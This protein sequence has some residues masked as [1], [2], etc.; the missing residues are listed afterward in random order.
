MTRDPFDRLRDANPVPEDTLPPPAMS[1]ADRIVHQRALR[2]PGGWPAWAISASVAL[3]VLFIGG[4]WLLWVRGDNR[5]PVASSP[6][7][8]SAPADVTT[9][10]A[11]PPVVEPPQEIPVYLLLDA[12]STHYLPGPYL[13]PVSRS[14]AVLSRPVG[15]PVLTAV[16]FLLAGPTPGEAEA[17]PAASTAIPPGTRVLG[18]E[19][20][21]R[22][23]TVDLSAE[24][25]SGGGTLSMR[26][27]LAQVVFTLTRFDHID[28]VRF[29][30]EGVPTTVF[31][32]EGVMVGDP[33]TRD[34]F[35][36]L[37]PL[38]MIE[39]PTY[40]GAASDSPL[41]VEGTANV[42]EA[43]VSL[44]LVDGNGLIIWEGF[45]TATCGSGCR[46]DFS[47]EIPYRVDRDQWGA[48]IGWQESMEDGSQMN[49]R[50]HPV[51]LVADTG[52]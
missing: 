8:T 9:T 48:V 15:D 16:E 18:L 35:D 43:T 52:D 12:D 36:D 7:Q 23:A 41:L 39:T 47:I 2:S 42:F 49:V 31:G 21:G 34:E 44:V 13:V 28:G 5:S 25:T 6:P 29:L 30:V 45:T 10:A 38:V 24:F 51:W 27:R 46:G 40:W 17:I 3:L 19:V 37:L 22:V 11:P 4:G 20:S 1:V 26:G 14:T 50:E 33:A 32:G